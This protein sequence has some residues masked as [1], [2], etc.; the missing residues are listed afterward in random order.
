MEVAGET[1]P[2]AGSGEV[3]CERR[4]GQDVTNEGDA[5]VRRRGVIPAQ[6]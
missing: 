4:E 3:L 2:G 5:G 6:G 1:L